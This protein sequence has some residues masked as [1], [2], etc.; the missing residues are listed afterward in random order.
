MNQQL[1]TPPSWL[2]LPSIKLS[3]PENS[4]YKF[5]RLF[6]LYPSF[7]I[8][9]LSLS[10][11]SKTQDVLVGLTSNGGP[12]GGGT[13]F[14]IKTTGTNFSIMKGFPEWGKNPEGNLI[15]GL[16]ANYYGM[17]RLGGSF[18][19]GT[20]F[21]MTPTGVMTIMHHFNYNTDGGNPY[22]SLTI[23][24]D[25]NYYG[26]TS[27]G[28]TNTYGTIFKMTPTGVYTLLKYFTSPDGTNPHGQMTVGLDS[29]FYGITNAG[30]ASGYGTIFKY[31]RTGVYTVLKS[32]VNLT[33]G[34]R[35]TGSLLRAN[36]GN[37]Y[38]GT[39]TGG[40]HNNGT[41]I[42]ITPSGI[43]TVLRNMNF[44]T[45][46][47]YIKS[48][49]VQ[50]PDHF[51]YGL[52]YG[53]GPSS[54]GTAFKINLD[55]T[56]FQVIHAFNNNAVE[57]SYPFGSLIVGTDG[58]LYGNTNI[59]GPNGTG[60]I[61]KMTT[62]G[63][64]TVLHSYVQVTEGGNPSGSLLK[65]FD[66]NYYG[67]TIRGGVSLY[68]TAFKI[69]ST[70]TF[71]VLNSFNGGIQGSVPFESMIQAIDKGLYGTTSGGGS[72]DNGAIFKICG[73]VTTIV[74]SFIRNTEGSIP[75]GSLIQAKDSNYY[76]LA[77]YGGT[78]SAG[79]VFKL[80]R[81][82]VFSVLHH[83]N[84]PTDGGIPLGSLL[85]GP[86]G[87][88][89]GMTS[90]GG[91]N[92][93]GTIFKISTTGVFSVLFAFVSATTG[94]APEGNL[95]LGADGNF[96]GMTRINPR[97]FNIT[98]GGILSVLKTLAFATDGTYPLG[99][100]LLGPDGNFYGTTSSGGTLNYG[101]IF[102]ITPGGV[103]TVLRQLNLIPDGGNPT[104][105]LVLSHDGNFYGMTNKG[106]T[107]GVGTIFRIST[108]GTYGVVRHLNLFPDGGTPFGSLLV[109][110]PNP[111]V[112]NAQKDTTN[113][114]TP[115]PIVLSGSGATPL[116]FLIST[117]PKHG[118]VTGSG[119]NKTYKP[120]LNYNGKDSFYFT[121]TWNCLVS[122]PAKVLV[123]I[124][125]VNDT[126]VL[127]AIGNKSA[128]VNT[129][130]TFTAKATDVDAGQTKTF[131][132]IG[133]PS[134]AT[135]NATT[136]VFNWTPT[137]AGT[138]TFKVRVID[139]G[140]PPLYD[141]EQII[142]TVAA[143]AVITTVADASLQ[144]IKPKENNLT[145]PV[146]FPNP[147]TDR[148][149]VRLRESAVRISAT[150][151]DIKGAMVKKWTSLEINDGNIQFDV[152]NLSPGTY[153]LILNSENKKWTFKFLKQ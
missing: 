139:N 101:T 75:K 71:K 132:L 46:G 35:P 149:I 62:T 2:Y 122:T 68:G 119:A 66:G 16:D 7:I 142:V 95:V 126:P 32:F 72:T 148:F 33:D 100:L 39:T 89:Y 147:V 106:G 63:T 138:D 127:A 70:G 102:R 24:T 9:L 60:T 67:L 45:D 136:G 34:G 140:V 23:G 15:K 152:G 52:T 44:A 146:L 56:N 111:L 4:I 12:Q 151:V 76:G 31:T 55:S 78:G 61:F 108:A 145:A 141:E 17:T 22:G 41:L 80:T 90:T 20:I 130:L 116:G 30:G 110:A 121:S 118:T 42:K 144:S 98:P 69:S 29:N 49:L 65:G 54:N 13:A 92:G 1:Q 129:L 104:G 11:Q 73:G 82:G 133:A 85:Q 87:Y 115:K 40:N 134:G 91:T 27:A 18:G 113:E 79:T 19:A 131:S 94:A 120:T 43:F 114:D 53:G 109:Q 57:G 5:A 59:G 117:A 10:L 8:L 64:L 47:Y 3:L 25:G 96:Y 83:F 112:A 97:V 88:L 125:P 93:S 84:S 135:I 137:S 51:L 37:F 48:D 105:N 150:I 28:G 86:D 81:T 128:T 58:L 107:Y 103:L 14:T 123:I 74:H 21:K 99:S 124:I 26:L 6:C 38:A 143:A 36:D 50:A 77:S 153:L